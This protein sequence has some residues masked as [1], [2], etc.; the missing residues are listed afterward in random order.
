MC[1]VFSGIVAGVEMLGAY[2]EFI[3]VAIFRAA[4]G[5]HTSSCFLAVSFGV[6]AVLLG[7]GVTAVVVCGGCLGRGW[8]L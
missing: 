8:I 2:S 7:K 1:G 6:M 5:E 4:A 3:M